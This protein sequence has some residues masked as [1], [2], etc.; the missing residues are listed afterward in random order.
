MKKIILLLLVVLLGQQMAY[1]QKT[2]KVWVVR[3]A[4]K[5][6]TDPKDKDP[7]L[8]DEGAKR[9]EALMK[10]LRGEKIDSIFTTNYKRTKL[11]GFPLADKIGIAMKTYDPATQKAFATQ[12]LA[13][14]QGKNILIV[15][16]SNTVLDLIEAFGATK[17]F[18]ALADDDYDFIF[19]ITIKGKKAEVKVDHYGKPQHSTAN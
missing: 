9:A 2:L 6:A 19:E 4:E 10:L 17:P 13:T 18:K 3:H 14:A 11:T 1:A 12:L 5:S 7:E 8:T 16:H 15:G